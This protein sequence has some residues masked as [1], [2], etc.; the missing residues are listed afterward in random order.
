MDE[1][2]VSHF[3]DCALRSG[4]SESLSDEAAATARNLAFIAEYDDR[5][6]YVPD[7]YP[8][9]HSYCVHEKGLEPQPAFKRI[10]AARLA[11]R[12]PQI[13]PAIADGRLTMT[14]VTVLASRLTEENAA[15]LLAAAAHKSKAQ[16]EELLAQRFPRPDVP[17]RIGPVVGQNETP[18]LALSAGAC[19]LSPE[20]V[21]DSPARITPLAPRRYSI[22]FTMSEEARDLLE[23]AQDLLGR[24]VDVPG[25]FEQALEVLVAKL[26]KQKFAV[27]DK[28]RKGAGR[29]SANLRCVPARV[30]REVRMRDGGQCTFTTDDGRRCPARS[31]LQFDHVIEVARGGEATTANL[32]LRCSAHNQYTAEQTFGAAFM[33][34]KREQ[35]RGERERRLAN[36][37]PDSRRIVPVDGQLDPVARPDALDHSDISEA[38]RR[39]LEERAREVA[40]AAAERARELDVIP[41]LRRLGVRATDARLAAERC[42]SMP[43]ATLE[44]RVRFALQSLAPPMRRRQP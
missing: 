11:R 19:Q 20:R 29:P 23:Y 32:R 3:T 28:P 21:A 36:A 39:E 34:N 9:M 37:G 5:K 1:Y 27:T 18:A 40:A 33:A 6:L 26:E 30:K 13:F 2:K 24:S 7:G 4:L 22:Q 16:I 10:T 15:E 41:W 44:E 43:D 14:S 38:D 35:G 25:V 31:H 12:F 17:T 42:E 8:S